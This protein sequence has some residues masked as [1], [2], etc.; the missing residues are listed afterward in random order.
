VGVVAGRRARFSWVVVVV[1]A[2]VV[3]AAVGMTGSSALVGSGRSSA[4]PV[5]TVTPSTNLVDLQQVN[6]TGSGFSAN[7]QIGTVQCRTGAVGQADCDLSTL[8]YAQADANGAFT[9]TRYVRRLIGVNAKTVDCG[10]P[11]GCI[12][13]AGNVANLSEAN[14]QTIFFNPN[15][16]P[17]VPKITVTPKTK[18]VDHQL[19]EVDG[20]GFSPATSV[21]I[22]QCVTHPPVGTF[23]VC[24]YSTSRYVT[25]GNDGTV[26]APNFA[27]ER[28][29]TEYTKTGL[30]KIDCAAAPG[31]CDIEAVSFS[32]G[33]S[34]PLSVPLSFDPNV[35]PVVSHVQVSP[36]SRLHDLQSVT[37][38][39]TGFT[40]GVAVSV[41]ECA[42]ESALLFASCD[43]TNSRSVT[44][45]FHGEFI[46]TFSARR[47]IA[48]FVYPT[49]V[50]NTDCA[51]KAGVC[52][53][54]VQG[55][56]SHD[57]T[58]TALAFNP[59]V[60]AVPPSI[61]ASPG[62]G[63]RDNQDVNV[64]LRGFAPAEPVTVIE[65][66]ADAIN[67]GGNTSYCDYTTSQTTSPAGT[68]ATSTTTHVHRAI[69]GQA[70]LVDCATKP[71]ACV[72]LAIENGYYGGSVV[73]SPTVPA[74]ATPTA[75]ALPPNG[76]S[77]PLKAAPGSNLPNIASTPLTF[78]TH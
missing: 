37:V 4:L 64:V 76:K 69:A 35:A 5:V 39:G 44:A 48:A 75:S 9:L 22:S 45:G 32:S 61:S 56:Q 11:S 10:A 3:L 52:D 13:G 12:L 49:G 25:V 43:Y 77:V 34:A 41:E 46:L 36:S 30:V 29:Q 53:L 68:G 62:T 71:G 51:T 17:Q 21:S 38:A 63:L 1:L 31:S 18:L 19:V 40:P 58:T 20:T 65:C 15:I 24:D 50:A 72:L 57:P 73:V 23:Q 33:N 67:E 78:S 55:S 26:Q 27:L 54:V 60:K 47:N 16:P 2:A 59:N 66:A 28:I 6:V 7:A 14:G 70:G 8:V 74:N 42:A